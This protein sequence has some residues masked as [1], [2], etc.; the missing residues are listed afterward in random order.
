M[1]CG[2]HQGGLLS[3]VNALYTDRIVLRRCNLHFTSSLLF[4]PL[5]GQFGGHS[6]IFAVP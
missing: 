5:N 3:F 6:K 1:A 4:H 2:D